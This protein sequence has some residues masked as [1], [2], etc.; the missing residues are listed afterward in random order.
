MKKWIEPE[1]VSIPQELEAVVGGYPLVVETLVRRGY[2]DIAT[3]RPFLDPAYFNPTS[4]WELPGMEAAVERVVAAIAGSEAICVWGDFDVD[5]QTSTTLL[6]SALRDLGAQVS[7]HI[8]VRATESHGVNWPVLEKILDQGIDLLLTCDTGIAAVEQVAYAQNRGVDVVVT[9]HHALPTELP[10]AHAVVNPRLVPEG[11]PL[12]TLPGVGVAYKLAEGLY[13]SFGRQGEG[14]QYLDL[15]ALGIVADIATLTGDTRYLLQLGLGNLRRPQRLGLKVLM[16]LSEI[17]PTWLTEEHIGFVIGPRLNA[18]GRLSDANPVVEF[19]TTGDEGR[20]RLLAYELEGLNARRR[21]LTDQVFQGALAQIERDPSLLDYAALVLSH[22]S[23]PAGVIGIVASR[24]V[25]RFNKPAI[26][27]SAQSGEAARG[28]ARSVEGVNIIEAIAAH[29]E[30]L[31][32]FGGHPMAAGLS[33]EPEL[34]PEFRIALSRTVASVLGEVPPEPTLQIDGYIPLST[35]SLDLVADLERLAPFGAGNP[36]LVLASR[37]LRKTNQQTV[38]RNGEHLLVTVEDDQGN[39]QRVIWWG[40]AGFL[41]TAPVPDGMFDLA[42]S[43]RASTFRGQRDVQLEWLDAMPVDEGIIEGREERE[44]IEVVDYRDVLHPLP[45][46]ERLRSEQ[47]IQIWSEADSKAKLNGSDRNELQPGE[48]LVIWSTPPAPSVLQRVLEIVSPK[49][50][51]LFAV[52]PDLDQPAE[53]LKRLAGLVKFVLQSKGGQ[54][55]ITS[56][57]AATAQLESIVEM[58]LAW[59]EAQ[60]HIRIIERSGD[61]LYMSENSLPVMGDEEEI[62]RLL[63]GMLEEVAAYRAYFKRAEAES[64][65]NVLDE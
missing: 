24:L 54:A 46:L 53:F 51:Y 23:W 32:S 4:P 28:S 10:D 22:P 37:G 63:K 15:V 38:G 36:P 31:L 61:R 65:I 56:L 13:Q 57:A 5:G 18:L 33:I 35:L 6:V 58:G 34:I 41:D 21:L 1:A 30:M 2:Q 44:P 45:V 43:V 19:L 48:N 12:G 9:D 64:L 3:A 39:A 26:L 59:L 49:Q 17:D 14:E 60:G 55:T 52:N 16:E 8:P 50:V 40:G 25:E 47:R 20:A 42:Y 62:A 11:H 27:I 7:Y 29:Q